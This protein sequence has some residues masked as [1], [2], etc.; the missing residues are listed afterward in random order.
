[1]K[2][3]ALLAACMVSGC[4]LW[5][6]DLPDPNCDAMQIVL[7]SELLIT[8]RDLRRGLN[9]RN[10]HR[11]ALSF[12]ARISSLGA[13]GSE[14]NVHGLWH[15]LGVNATTP[16]ALPFR[17]LA[18]VNRTDL[19]EQLAPESPA[20][21]ARIVYTLTD[22]PGDDPASPSLPATVIFEYSLGRSESVGVWARRFHALASLHNL[23]Q[24]SAALALLVGRFAMGWEEA[25]EGPRLSQVRVSDA[26]SG[27]A[28][29]REFSVQ[30]ASLI[31]RG[32][33]NT[34]RLDL[35][36]SEQLSA[37]VRAEAGSIRTGSHRV[38]EA[39][40]A[41]SAV[42]SSLGWRTNAPDAVEHAFARATCSGCHSDLG[43]ANAGFHLSESSG[44]DVVLSPFLADEDLPRREAV[45]RERL[46]NG[47]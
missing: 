8:D 35:A 20:G 39:W 44:G 42:V 4:Q 24:R 15:L 16:A 30:G 19:A 25:E 10:Q 27:Q 31:E 45:L 34:P 37:F 7:E 32:L 12:N 2:S 29:L 28:E 26:R 13:P 43:P 36:G 22:G 41:D 47:E 40:L 17:L 23:E 6:A 33:R 9:A 1:V 5:G 38:P 21:E 18:V 46:C 14:V 11:G 3:A